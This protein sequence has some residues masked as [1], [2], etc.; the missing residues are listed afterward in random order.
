MRL[1]LNET[2]NYLASWTRLMVSY[3]TEAE[4]RTVLT[5]DSCLGSV[6]VSSMPMVSPSR[7]TTSLKISSKLSTE[8][9]MWGYVIS[10]E[11]PC[12]RYFIIF[13]AIYKPLVDPV[14]KMMKSCV[15][16]EITG[17]CIFTVAKNILTSKFFELRPGP[18]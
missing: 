14:S 8:K 18:D 6:A 11:S 9:Q 3:G 13:F 10:S 12:Y 7:T 16:F 17:V 5:I 2:G 15:Q 4:N 1:G